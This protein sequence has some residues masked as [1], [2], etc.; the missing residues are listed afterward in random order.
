M[1]PT[2]QYTTRHRVFCV[3]VA[4]IG[5]V[6]LLGGM[7]QAQDGAPSNQATP[8]QVTVAG[9]VGSRHDRTVLLRLPP[10][11][12]VQTAVAGDLTVNDGSQVLPASA[13]TVDWPAP[14]SADG[15]GSTETNG[16]DASDASKTDAPE[17]A[18]PEPTAPESAASEP[19]VAPL[20][21]TV[22]VNLQGVRPGQYSGQLFVV[23]TAGE[24]PV[25]LAVTVKARA[26]W[27]FLVLLAGLGLGI[28]LSTYRKSGRRRD[29]VLMR[30]GELHTTMEADPKLATTVGIAF[31]QNIDRVLLDAQVALH[32]A[33]WAGASGKADAA[34]ALYVTWTKY[35]DD[36]ANYSQV[37]DELAARIK[38]IDTPFMR[39]VRRG[40]EDAV[41]AAPTQED[42]ASLK[43]SL[44]KLVRYAAENKQADDALVQ[45]KQLI[46]LL[47]ARLDKQKEVRD[48]FQEKLAGY[49]KVLD[50]LRP[51]SDPDY[52]TKFEQLM[53]GVGADINEI[54][55]ALE[56]TST[57]RK[58]GDQEGEDVSSYGVN[59]LAAM[60][61]PPVGQPIG[62]PE[63]DKAMRNLRWFWIGSYAVALTLLAL[64][65]FNEL[66]VTKLTFGATPWAD[67]AA[68]LAWGFGAE[69]TRAAVTEVVRN[70]E[71][72]FGQN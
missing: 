22:R 34:Q 48:A 67:Y 21:V 44:E 71:I 37:V 1:N 8:S 28:G 16:A 33:D 64:A 29:Q 63:A 2:L 6:L 65:G 19:V 15:A 32:A 59:P 38:P 62:K 26:F 50:S 35:A 24:V 42:P 43:T 31:R 25:N 55:G 66:Y 58:A 17:S 9:A 45:M 12:T 69:A 70:W 23:T 27:P 20:P 11:V 47:P 7:A 46:G 14:E 54:K 72:P 53:T 52:A 18:A 30:I 4:L 10:D 61:V 40:L 13:L 41:A 39:D 57:A 3:L 56:T 51:V 36:W 68:L 5:S 49:L 60:A